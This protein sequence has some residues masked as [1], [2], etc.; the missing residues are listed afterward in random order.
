MLPENLDE[1]IKDFEGYREGIDL[2]SD[3]RMWKVKHEE[4][5][6]KWFLKEIAR[7][8]HILIEFMKEGYSR[9]HE[10]NFNHFFLRNLAYWFAEK[11]NIINALLKANGWRGKIGFEIAKGK[12]KIYHLK[13]KRLPRKIDMRSI[14]G[15]IEKGFW[16]EY[17]IFSWNDILQSVFGQVN[18]VYLRDIYLGEEGLDSAIKILLDFKDKNNRLP[19][20]TDIE[21]KGIVNAIYR[22]IWSSFG[23]TSW[24]VL[25]HHVFNM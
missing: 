23:I 3:S 17:G 16:K 18:F 24:N 12:L 21:M 8:K 15:A 9:K 25:L 13:S 6:S 7:I 4:L 14:S 5:Y 19:K 11:E 20:A 1:N 2:W 22:G 10:H